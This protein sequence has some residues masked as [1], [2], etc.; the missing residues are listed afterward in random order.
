M[1]PTDYNVEFTWNCVLWWL[2]SAVLSVTWI[3]HLG[4]VVSGL[5]MVI[6]NC[7][8]WERLNAATHD[9]KPQRIENLDRTLYLFL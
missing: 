5:M 9:T 8:S 7:L 3:F 4:M 1:T 6:S 2:V